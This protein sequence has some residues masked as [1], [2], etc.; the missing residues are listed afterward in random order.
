MDHI[1]NPV[2]VRPATE[3][4]AVQAPYTSVQLAEMFNVSEATIRNRWFD[5]IAKV[6]P[7]P[8]LKEGKV[9]T[10]LA[11][12]LFAE[13]AQIPKPERE[14]WVEAAKSRYAHEFGPVGVVA[15]LVPEDLGG[16]LAIAT[17]GA[18][19]DMALYQATLGD[20]N[21]FLDQLGTVEAEISEAELE[22]ARQRGAMRGAVLAKA[23][24]EAQAATQAAVRKQWQARSAQPR[25]S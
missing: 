21:A 6:A 12:S 2:A 19:A 5:W 8:L 13:F 25:K 3:Q 4:N 17:Q 7:E 9:Y 16:A 23:E 20:I 22:A 1:V 15:E 11:R 14:L 24:I 10:E 18:Q